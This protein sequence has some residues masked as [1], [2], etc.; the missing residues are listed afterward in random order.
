LLWLFNDTKQVFRLVNTAG[1][2][3]EWD[4]IRTRAVVQPVAREGN[5]MQFN[6]DFRGGKTGYELIQAIDIE[7]F[8]A[9]CAKGALELLSAEKP[10]SGKMTVIADGDISGLIAHEVC[11]HASE[12]DEVVKKRSF[13]TDMAGV[14]VGTDL[15][16]MVDDGTLKE[17]AGSYPFDSEGTPS[18]RTVIIENGVFKGYM[19]TIE[20]A[21]L[22]GVEPT[23]NGRAQDYN[24]RIFARMTNT[25]FDVGDWKDEDIIAD[26]KD[27]LYVAKSLSG[28]E[29]VVGGG[30]QCSALKGYII[31]N[32][33]LTQLVR[34][35]TLAGKVL[36]ILKTVDAVGNKLQFSGG[37]CGKGEED[38][39]P[40][41]SGGPH[42][43]MEMVVGGG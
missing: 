39:I 10:P 6:Y 7:P 21:S 9:D 27:G 35:M 38:Y 29:D 1:S 16:T 3:L 34:S 41:T 19:H 20:T 13:L 5:K 15:V 33:E 23:G 32:G 30:V 40:V 14:K 11:G 25:F 17:Y 36:E 2:Q 18:S 26:T 8:G 42:M 43:R 37:T 22:M 24:R 12:A 28:M 31:K 4:E